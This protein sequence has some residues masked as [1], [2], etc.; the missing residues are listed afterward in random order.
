[1]SPPIT[2][3]KPQVEVA[4]V[5]RLLIAEYRNAYPLAPNQHW[6][7]LTRFIHRPLTPNRLPPIQSRP[8]II[9]HLTDQLLSRTK[10]QTPVWRWSGS[11]KGSSRFRLVTQ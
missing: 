10:L 2:R 3:P 1:M 8:V 9:R 6:M 4:D 7:F 5:L 11:P